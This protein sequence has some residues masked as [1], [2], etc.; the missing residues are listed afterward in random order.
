[1]IVSA[2]CSSFSWNR[3]EQAHWVAS[4][5]WYGSVVLSTTSVIEAFHLSIFL[6]DAEVGGYTDKL[7]RE[8]LFGSSEKAKPFALYALQIPI[9]MLSWSLISYMTGLS[10]LVCE[11][12]WSTAVGSDEWKVCVCCA[13]GS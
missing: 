5:A 13:C 3:L 8:K 12:W 10:L 1:M 7:L 2:V 6:S 9:M 11:A 4:A